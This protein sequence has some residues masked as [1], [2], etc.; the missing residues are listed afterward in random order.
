MQLV[1][2]IDIAQD[3]HE[4]VARQPRHGIPT[5]Q[6]T[7]QAL[8][9]F[10]QQ[11]VTHG[12]PVAV[13]DR[14]ETIQV[15][16]AH[17][18][19]DAFA[20]RVGQSL[21][22]QVGQ[23]G[24]VGQAGEHIVAH[25]P[26]QGMQQLALLRDVKA[27]RHILAHLACQRIDQW[28]HG[29]VDPVQRTVLGPVADFALPHPPGDQSPPHADKERRFMQP[30]IEDAV[31]GPQQFFTAVARDAAELLIDV[32]DVPTQVGFRKDCG[33]VHGR[34]IVIIHKASCLSG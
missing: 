9:H 13:V 12:M 4:F 19:R 8:R 31:V 2:I 17:R 32:G 7:L 14:L 5:T 22:Q 1:L 28:H 11:Q 21:V 24:A 3:Q 27:D 33:R 29:A 10:H 25:P 23:V 26:L 30:G 18:Q 15:E 34:A 16:H 20:A 6:D